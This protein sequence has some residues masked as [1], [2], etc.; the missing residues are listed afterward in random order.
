MALERKVV[1]WCKRHKASGKVAYRQR[2][3]ADLE[4]VLKFC[5]EHN[6]GAKGRVDWIG[7]KDLVAYWV[8]CEDQAHST[9]LATYRILV[10]FF[11]SGVVAS[12]PKVPMPKRFD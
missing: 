11:G 8:S 9:R 4:R 1:A 2:Q 5:F 3:V 10:K 12:P 7:K 6:Q